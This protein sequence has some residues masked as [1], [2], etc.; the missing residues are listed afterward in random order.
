MAHDIMNTPGGTT[1]FK[2][3]VENFKTKIKSNRNEVPFLDISRETNNSS[4][5]KFIDEFEKNYE[6]QKERQEIRN[7]R[8][9]LGTTMC[10]L[11]EEE[12]FVN[13]FDISVIGDAIPNDNTFS[14]KDIE[15][16]IM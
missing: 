9:A 4:N 16:I 1:M 15:S 6:M 8:R 5:K 11:K 13:D 14:T 7:M 2:K 10:N 12:F 3:K